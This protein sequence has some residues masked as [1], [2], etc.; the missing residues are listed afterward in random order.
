MIRVVIPV[1]DEKGDTLSE[2]FGRAPYFVWFDVEDGKVVDKGVTPNDSEHFGGSGHPPDRMAALGAEV[3]ISTGMGMRAIQMFQ[4]KR[5]PVLE[6]ISPSTMENL[7]A[8]KNN[9]LKELTHGC[10]HSKH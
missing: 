2:H 1:R 10:L 5:I 4:D 3:V 8:F 7:E 6:A 9:G